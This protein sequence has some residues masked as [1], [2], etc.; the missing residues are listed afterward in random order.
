VLATVGQCGPLLGK[1]SFSNFSL[2]VLDLFS[3]D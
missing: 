3:D 1:F 2:E